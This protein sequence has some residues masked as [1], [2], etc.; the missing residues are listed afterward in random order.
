MSVST[1]GESVDLK[2]SASACEGDRWRVYAQK[3]MV[4]Q[5]AWLSAKEKIYGTT[6][7]PEPESTYSRRV[8]LHQKLLPIPVA[9]RSLQ[10][11]ESVVAQYEYL[12]SETIFRVNSGHLDQV[13][14]ASPPC[15]PLRSDN[16]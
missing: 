15:L 3:S 14:K 4:A 13:L 16:A 5:K 9:W 10:C 8:E 11:D 7:G 6:V 12:D 2:I 1:V